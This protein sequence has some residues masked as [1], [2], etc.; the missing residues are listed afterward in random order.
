MA[1]GAPRFWKFAA[2]IL[3]SWCGSASAAFVDSP[4]PTAAAMY[5]ACDG[6]LARKRLIETDAVTCQTQLLNETL[7]GLLWKTPDVCRPRD[8]TIEMMAYAYVVEYL[9]RVREMGE[10]SFAG[11]S[12][13][14]IAGEGFRRQWRCPS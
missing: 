2:V 8:P 10:A 14:L 7:V 12:W 3:T 1:I 9:R 6:L 13:A 4:V 11:Q 5:I